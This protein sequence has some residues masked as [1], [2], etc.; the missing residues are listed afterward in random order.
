MLSWEDALL[1][2]EGS[3]GYPPFTNLNINAKPRV[4]FCVIWCVYIYNL[5]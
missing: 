3:V 2:T 4:S 1:F 5:A